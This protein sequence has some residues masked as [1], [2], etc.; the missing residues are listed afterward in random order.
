MTPAE[1]AAHSKKMAVKKEEDRVRKIAEKE[2]RAAENIRLKEERRLE[3][4][5]EAVEAAQ[6]RAKK[7]VRQMSAADKQA[8][9]DIAAH[10]MTSDMASDKKKRFEFL[11]NSASGDLFRKFVHSSSPKKKSRGKDLLGG[12]DEDGAGAAS[13]DKGRRGRK[14]EKEE[15]AEILRNEAKSSKSCFQFRESPP[16]I[17]GTMRDYQVGWLTTR[18]VLSPSPSLFPQLRARVPSLSEQQKPRFLP[19]RTILA[20]GAVELID[21][22]CCS[23]PGPWPQLD[24]R[25]GPQWSQRN[26]RRRDGAG[27]DDPVVLTPW[28]SQELPR[29][30]GAR[31]TH[32]KG[33]DVL[34]S[35][36]PKLPR[37]GLAVTIY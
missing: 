1:R 12:D 14:T 27:Q 37:G 17:K 29:C 11:L 8:E 32:G 19:N 23:H 21:C 26:P 4:K 3:K 34:V 7:A 2:A 10:E 31:P 24:D 20:W 33:G 13:P 18:V 35:S 36:C 30:E 15:D 16:Y 28:L 9:R 25:T 5:R 22:A 6:R